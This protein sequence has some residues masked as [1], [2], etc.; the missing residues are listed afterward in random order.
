MHIKLPENSSYWSWMGW[1]LQSKGCC[2]N[3]LRLWWWLLLFFLFSSCRL[4]SAFALSWCLV[5]PCCS[6]PSTHPRSS[7]SG[8]VR[9]Q[10]VNNHWIINVRSVKIN[11][12]WSVQLKPKKNK[13][14]VSVKLDL[15]CTI[16]KPL[17][18]RFLS[19]TI[20]FR[21]GPTCSFIRHRLLRSVQSEAGT[22]HLI[23]SGC[24]KNSEISEISVSRL[25]VLHSLSRATSQFPN[26]STFFFFTALEWSGKQSNWKCYGD[27]QLQNKEKILRSCTVISVVANVSCQVNK[28]GS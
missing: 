28:L 9:V 8:W 23:P 19:H 4:L 21:V 2:V 11:A 6:P 27:T 18:T 3:T 1:A 7:P 14:D 13:K 10:R 26:I 22:D 15:H 5:T 12:V 25:R 20:H 16:L 24:W 17:L